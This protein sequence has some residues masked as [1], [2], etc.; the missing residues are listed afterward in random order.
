VGTDYPFDMAESDPLGH[1]AAVE[2]L[3]PSIA[4]KIGGGNALALL[5]I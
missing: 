5:G 3:D 1:L 4:E 2:G